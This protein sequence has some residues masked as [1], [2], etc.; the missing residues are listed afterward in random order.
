MRKRDNPLFA[1]EQRQITPARLDEAQRQ[2][3]EEIVAFIPRFRGLVLKASQLKPN[4]GSEVLLALKEELDR[5]YEEARGLADD[6]A[7]TLAAIEKLVGLIMAAI[8]KGAGDDALA[9]AELEQEDAARKAHFSLVAFPLVADLLYPESPIAADELAATLL[10]S[11]GEELKAALE[12]FDGEQLQALGDG[13]RT[14]LEQSGASEPRF[15]ANLET[16]EEAAQQ[17]LEGESDG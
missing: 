2:D 5:A 13:A 7:E 9:L 11:E 1:P 14:L 16:I 6:Q 12:V 4:E 10:S 8:R 3:H 15:I 17:A